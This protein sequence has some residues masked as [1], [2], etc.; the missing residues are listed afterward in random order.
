MAL[1]EKLFRQIDIDERTLYARLHG[2]VVGSEARRAADGAATAPAAGE[3]PVAS[4]VPSSA[5]AI[6][7]TKLAAIRRETAGITLVLSEIFDE[8]EVARLSAPVVALAT[9][10]RDDDEGGLDGLDRRHRSLAVEIL[11]RGR[12]VEERFRSSRFAASV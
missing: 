12:M 8:E 2:D 10:R 11:D 9:P 4:A 6:D 7:L 1:L 3:V 5:A